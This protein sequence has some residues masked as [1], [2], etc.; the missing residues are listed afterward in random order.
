[1]AKKIKEQGQ[2]MN[3]HYTLHV[4]SYLF[5]IS[6]RSEESPSFLTFQDRR[7]FQAK[8]IRMARKGKFTR[9]LKYCGIT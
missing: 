6:E 7:P 1:M 9:I 5:V 2:F 3:C 4:N 8:V